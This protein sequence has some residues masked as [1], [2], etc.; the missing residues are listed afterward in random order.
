MNLIPMPNFGSQAGWSWNTLHWKGEP[1]TAWPGGTL[2]RA[3]GAEWHTLNPF[4]E[5]T[6]YGW[7]IM[8]RAIDGL[9]SVEPYTLT[10]I[11]NIATYYETEPWVSIPELGIKEGAM[12]T[13]YL[14]QDVYWHDGKPV[15]A[16]DCVNTMRLMR[17][18][19]PGRY[20]L[21]WSY[22]VYEEADGPYKFTTYHLF[23]SLY[24][25]DAVAGTALLAPKHVTDAIE[26]KGGNILTWDFTKTYKDLMGVDPPA[27]YSFMKQIVGCGPYVYDYADMSTMTAHVV[28]YDEYFI[29]APVIGGVVGEWRVN[30]DTAYTYEVLVQNIAAKENSVNGELVNATVNVKVYEDDVLKYTI[31]NV[32]LTPFAYQYL[33]PYTTDAYTAGHYGVHT[34]KVEVYDAETTALWHTYNHK[35]VVVPRED[36]TTYSGDAIIKGGTLDCK[37]DISDI[38]RTALAYGSKPKSLNW[39][40]PCDVNE[41]YKVD[42]RDIFA[43]ALKYGWRAPG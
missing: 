19:K 4:T 16:Y 10:N 32:L 37:V 20:S 11:P 6:L 12:V 27:K 23:P 3:L 9:L 36:V 43:I 29:S 22:L 35:F 31:N 41:D 38:F 24:W 42:I 39:D 5:D 7:Q 21:T 28:K 18:Y 1:G 15:T 14:R 8:D 40:P 17:E 13:F 26:K 25:A 33:G 30:P 2:K 34:I